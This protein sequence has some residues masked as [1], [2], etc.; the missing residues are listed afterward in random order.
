MRYVHVRG[1]TVHF[2]PD[3]NATFTRGEIVR[4]R[5]SSNAGML[6]FDLN[7]LIVDGVTSAYFHR[8]ELSNLTAFLQTNRNVTHLRLV[9]CL[10]QDKFS[11]NKIHTITRIEAGNTAID[12][13][14]IPPE[15]THLTID[16]FPG[17]KSIDFMRFNT[18]IRYLKLTRTGVRSLEPLRNN[19]TLVSLD[20]SNSPIE[21]LDPLRSNRTITYFRVI[22]PSIT[23][24][25]PIW[26]NTSITS[27]GM[28]Y[29]TPKSRSQAIALIN[30]FRFNALNSIPR[31]LT[32]R[33]L[34]KTY[35]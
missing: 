30:S 18:S 2:T 1:N 20:I 14:T 28:G 25:S 13:D 35:I 17:L 23:D 9:D 19:I 29:T 24:L 11:L 5:M 8:C 32:L 31:N 12:P 15:V 16:N 4:M 26:G 34:S 3:D 21:S 6:I 10:F 22:V 33:F 27:W 7:G